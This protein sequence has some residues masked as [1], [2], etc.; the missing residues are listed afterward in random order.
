MSH[1]NPVLDNKPAQYKK[2]VE[3]FINIS[4]DDVPR[5]SLFQ[6]LASLAMQP[7]ISATTA[8]STA[9]SA[10]PNADPHTNYLVEHS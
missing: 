3:G 8:G 7:D 9:S 5:V 2:N 10:L 1:K 4:Y 6:P